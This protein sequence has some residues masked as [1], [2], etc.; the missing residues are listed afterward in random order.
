MGGIMGH[1]HMIIPWNDGVDADGKA[2]HCPNDGS[3]E[4]GSFIVH[5]VARS[6]PFSI[7]RYLFLLACLSC[8]R[9]V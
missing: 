5:G 7:D 6:F 9:A 8:R 1:E 3:P 2:D 4:K